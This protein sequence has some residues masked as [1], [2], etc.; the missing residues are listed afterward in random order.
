[1][2]ILTDFGLTDTLSYYERTVTGMEIKK[3]GLGD[4]LVM[5]KSHPCDKSA[6][7]FLVLTLG[8]DIKIRCIACGREVT[9]P[10]IKLEKS[11]KSI[12]SARESE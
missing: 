6:T 7:R 1:M 4:V 10:R 2:L 8:S 12:E 5:K 11:I 3:I 9:V